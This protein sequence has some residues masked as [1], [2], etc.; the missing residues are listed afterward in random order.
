MI[1]TIGTLKSFYCFLFSATNNKH[2]QWNN[3]YRKNILEVFVI[4]RIVTI[5]NVMAREVL[6]SR[7][8]PTVEVEVVTEFGDIGRAIVPSGASTGEAE[9][10]ELRDKDET[11]YNGNGVK[12]AVNN[13][14]EIIAEK[15]I[16]VNV[17]DQKEI[18]RLMIKLDGTDNKSKLGANAIL[19]VSMA[20]AC[21]AANSLEIPLAMYLGGIS[22]SSIPCPMMNILNG[23]QHADNNVNIQ[24]FMIVPNGIK[25]F[26]E[27]VRACSE[28]YYALKKILKDEELLSGVGDEGGFAPNLKN[29]E[30]ALEF[31]NNAIKKADYDGKVMISID[32]AASEMY[33]KKKKMYEFWKTGEK[34]TARE[35]ITYYKELIEKYPIFSIEDGL[36][37]EDWDGW[38]LMTDELGKKIY[39]VGDDLF[40]TNVKRLKYGI[41]NK[42]ANSILIKPNQIGTVSETIETVKEAKANGYLP[43][44]SHRSGET[45]DT[46][47]AD[48]SVGLNVKYIKTGA[49]VRG[50]RTAKYNQLLRLN[51]MING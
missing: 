45:E 11:R 2:F 26:G 49:P 35:M 31:L 18:D 14:N 39:L 43:I 6:D 34:K 37:E 8:K 17:Y 40:V 50:E 12:K 42:I 32:V 4:K 51:E 29:D 20:T 47:I 1:K 48:L 23:G 15:L 10:I 13:V 3:M 41:E 36:A 28:I 21:A 5:E 25:S 9:A 22:G 44:I 33:D 24:E 38:K 7:G 46:F 16:G 19:G 30:E 27:K